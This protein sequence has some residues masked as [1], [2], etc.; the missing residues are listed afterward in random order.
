M[1]AAQFAAERHKN[2]RRKGAARE[3]YVNH[4]IEVAGLLSDATDGKD[5]DLVLAGLLHDLIEDQG[6]SADDVASQFGVGVA[7]LVLEVTD[8]KNLSKSERKHLRIAHAARKSPRARMLKIAD[9]ISNLRSLRQSPPADWSA[10]RQREYLQWAHDVVAA[11]R[12]VSPRL[13]SSFDQAYTTGLDSF[14]G[15]PTTRP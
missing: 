6:V 12:G 2:Q 14:D 3:P 10:E 9:L 4:L 5:T 7:A 15:G 13:E 1:R 11:C 8:D